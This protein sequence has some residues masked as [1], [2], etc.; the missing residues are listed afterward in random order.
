MLD[1][2]YKGFVRSGALLND[3]NKKI[4]EEI[5]RDLSLKSL[6]FGQNVLAST[7]AYFKHITDEKELAGIP[8][9]VIEQYKTE[10]EE[11]NLEGFAITLDY[12]SYLPAITYAENRNLRA[13]LALAN[14]KKSF[15]NGEW[16]NQNLV[17]ELITLKQKKAELLGYQNYATYVLE[18]RMAETPQKVFHF[19]KFC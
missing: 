15:D 4:L 17:K 7:N 5:N 6:Q 18:E 11:R 12:P 1:E 19:E 3:E 2:T 8:E 13:E 16:D 9:S 10:A 14:G